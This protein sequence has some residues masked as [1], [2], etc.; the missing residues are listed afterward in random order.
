VRERKVGRTVDGIGLAR[1]DDNILDV[2]MDR[3]LLS[4]HEAGAAVDALRGM[5]A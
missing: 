5:V 4:A 3:R 2:L 1:L